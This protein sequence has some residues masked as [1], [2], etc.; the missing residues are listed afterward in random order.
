MGAS[1][2][3]NYKLDIKE[4]T[5]QFN[6]LY[7]NCDMINKFNEGFEATHEQI[8]EM[9]QNHAFKLGYGGDYINKL[10]GLNC[11]YIYIYENDKSILF[12][13]STPDFENSK[14]KK[15]GLEFFSIE[16]EEYFNVRIPKSI[17]KAIDRDIRVAHPDIRRK[18]QFDKWELVE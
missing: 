17:Y 6:N 16:P 14:N 5:E 4:M 15:I 3:N 8:S 12:N 9:V 10:N 2:M 7:D 18:L 11:R 1:R 13:L